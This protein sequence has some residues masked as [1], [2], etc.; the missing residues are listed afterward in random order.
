MGEL[1]TQSSSYP[2]TLDTALALSDAVDNFMASHQN[3]VLGAMVNVQAELGLGLKG[4]L[5]N[6]AARLAVNISGSGGVPGGT[7]FPASPGPQQMFW[8]SDL[9]QLN[10]YD[11]ALGQWQRIDSTNTHASLAGLAADDHP[12][13]GQIATTETISAV[14]TFTANPVFNPGIITSLQILDNTIVD[15]DISASASIA[16]SKLVDIVNADIAAGAAIAQSKLVDIVDVDIAAGA[17]IAQSKINTTNFAFIN[18]ANIFTQ[19]QEIRGGVAFIILDATAGTPSLFLRKSGVGVSGIRGISTDTLDLIDQASAAKVGWDLSGTVGNQT[20]G[21]VP[22]ARMQRTEVNGKLTAGTIGSGA[23]ILVTLVMGTVN[24]GDRVLIDGS[25]DATK[26]GTSGKTSIL[27]V[28]SG[29]AV[30]VFKQDFTSAVDS[31]TSHTNGTILSK[32]IFSIGRITTGGT[33]SIVLQGISAGS[34]CSAVDA[35]I[36]AIVLNNG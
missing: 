16:Q 5:A 31:E 11:S 28:S 17:N 1:T 27:I 14:W 29:T 24:P 22:L 26:G 36:N 12:Q 13:Y 33:L 3:G 30:M 9:K 20:Q 23:T 8:R 6:L 2:A 35:Q 34:D 18:V 25:F 4:T 19:A 15:G 10:I 21:I 32:S 7:S